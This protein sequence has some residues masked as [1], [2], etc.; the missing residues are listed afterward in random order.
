MPGAGSTRGA[1]RYGRA[2][3]VLALAVMGL[4]GCEY[5]PDS[6]PVERLSPA[7]AAER[8]RVS[9]ELGD[10]Q[11]AIRAA[12]EAIRAAPKDPSYRWLLSTL[13]IENGEHGA[14]EVVLRRMQQLAMDHPDM[15]LRIAR[16]LY[17]NNKHG[18]LLALDADALS[19]QELG[20][21]QRA[22]L[23]YLQ[24]R[25]LSD[26]GRGEAARAAF[27]RAYQGFEAARSTAA[28]SG[29]AQALQRE[30]WL[31]QSSEDDMVAA[32]EH[33]TCLGAADRREVPQ[34][35]LA[36]PGPSATVWQVGPS[37][38]LK[39]LRAAAAKIRNGD[40]VLI[41]AGEYR[42][43]VRW[44]ARNLTLRAASQPVNIIA[45]PGSRHGWQVQG[46]DTVVEGLRFTGGT[47]AAL[48]VSAPGFKLLRSTVE[49]SAG[50]LRVE[51]DS[52]EVLIEFSRFID[53]GDRT[54]AGHNVSIGPI[55]R[56]TFRY[57]EVARAR[58]GHQLRTE[59]TLNDIRHNRF[60][61]GGE[62]QGRYLVDIT[63]GGQAYVI[64][65]LMLQS[66]NPLSETLIAYASERYL[67]PGEVYVTHN[68]VQ[69]RSIDG[70]LLENF[71]AVP[72]RLINNLFFGTAGRWVKGE[73][74]RLGNINTSLPQLADP[75]E[76]DYRPLA[77]SAAVDAGQDSSELGAVRLSPTEEYR[78]PA[79]AEPRPKAWR[80]DVGAYEYCGG[81]Y[82]D[83]RS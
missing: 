57:N 5:A 15:Q 18:E 50:G 68:S 79:G 44:A 56:L 14:A 45:P 60:D 83:R 7:E 53:N 1:A 59:A 22:G 19:D 30:M 80:L 49:A 39:T 24:G 58:G 12:R 76:G 8:A 27:I 28:L 36:P 20:A 47:G 32:V 34:H 61:D 10:L 66:Y 16:T 64:G 55:E 46:E 13:L 72:A 70:V 4:P 17:L 41:D 29:E 78:H 35:R 77:D 51:T 23:Y 11:E 67:G 81:N 21:G 73:G 33:A 37:R 75:G 42:E 69:N 74:V 38:A 31:L 3:F 25:V 63:R 48:H 65:N 52:G 2:A 9:H 26:E 6:T 40:H 71:S 82:L 43:S 62:A 54:D